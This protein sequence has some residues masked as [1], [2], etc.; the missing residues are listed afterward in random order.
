MVF[1]NVFFLLL[2]LHILTTFLSL[3]FS[4]HR[5][6]QLTQ[7]VRP[8]AISAASPRRPFWRNETH[9][10]SDGKMFKC[11]W[12]GD[13]KKNMIFK[14]CLPIWFT[15]RFQNWH[16]SH[17]IQNK[18][19]GSVTVITPTRHLINGLSWTL[20]QFAQT[21]TQNPVQQS[22]PRELYMSRIQSTPTYLQHTAIHLNTMYIYNT[23]NIHASIIINP[24]IRPFCSNHLH[25]R[26]I[27]DINE[28]TPE[29]MA[30][31]KDVHFF[32]N[33]IDILCG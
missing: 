5:K 28:K 27:N 20:F 23:K 16:F 30:R 22:P 29:S 21:M 7:L 12:N 13:V 33:S 24:Q 1:L 17:T 6:S 25:S 10:N 2:L 18:R 9:G 15:V 4:F 3:R 31:A 26:D 8:V 11:N 19:W 14:N 32:K